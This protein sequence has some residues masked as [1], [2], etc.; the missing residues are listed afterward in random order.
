VDGVSV[1]VTVLMGVRVL[2]AVEGM[3]V[4]VGGSEGVKVL[5][6]PGRGVSDGRGVCV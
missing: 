3:G 4:P 5:V 6:A 2:V 1:L